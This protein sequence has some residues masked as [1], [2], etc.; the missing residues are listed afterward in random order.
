MRAGWVGICHRSLEG[1]SFGLQVA[2][3][4][5]FL[6]RL[7]ANEKLDPQMSTESLSRTFSWLN[8]CWWFR[9]PKQ[10]PDLYKTPVNNGR[11]SKKS[12]KQLKKS[13]L[14]IHQFWI[15]L[16]SESK[17]IPFSH[18]WWFGLVQC[19]ANLL[20]STGRVRENHC[21]FPAKSWMLEGLGKYNSLETL[22]FISQRCYLFRN[23]QKSKLIDIY[24]LLWS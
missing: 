14:K 11:C 12:M 7:Y 3:S 13:F 6:P 5:V 23:V 17:G 22:F 10:P 24:L 16:S 19:L 4:V 8:Y 15:S 2:P 21:H 9:N 1:I 18:D 20:C